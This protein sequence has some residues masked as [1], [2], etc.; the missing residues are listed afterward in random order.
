MYEKFIWTEKYSVNVA[1]ID[2]QHQKFIS[3]CNHLLESADSAETI[4]RKEALIGIE[5]LGDYAFYHLATEE[6]L[7]LK[8]NYPNTR[9]HI[10]SHQQ[11][12]EKTKYLIAKI[13]D[14]HNDIRE[15]LQEAAMFAGNWLLHHIM[16]T[17]KEY[18]EFFN[19]HGII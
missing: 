7:F 6:E 12:R 17:D 19:Q 16:T 15:T 5:M 1:E 13:R 14:E 9:E 8:L 3:I 18:T 4:T 11:F 10:E 2:A